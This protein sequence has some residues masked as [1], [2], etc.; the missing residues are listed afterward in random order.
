MSA[1]VRRQNQPAATCSP[2]P[3]R[4]GIH[5]SGDGGRLQAVVD[6]H[7]E[8]DPFN[9]PQLRHEL[10]QLIDDGIAD[11]TVDLEHLRLCTSH[12]LDLLDEIHRRLESHGGGELRLHL[13][14]APQVVRRIVGIVCE[15][16][17][18]FG[19]RVHA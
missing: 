4:T 5:V 9:V 11:I 17:P 13:G 1:P 8:L 18:S 6:L 2:A 14:R 10:E 15:R 12:G 19:P 3:L 7:G 16:D